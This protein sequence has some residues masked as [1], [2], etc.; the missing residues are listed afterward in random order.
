MFPQFFGG[1]SPFGFPK[2]QPQQKVAS[3][4]IRTPGCSHSSRAKRT[5]SAAEAASSLLRIGPG[6]DLTGRRTLNFPRLVGWFELAGRSICLNSAVLRT[7]N[8]SH[9]SVQ[10]LLPELCHSFTQLALDMLAVGTLVTSERAIRVVLWVY[11]LVCI[12]LSFFVFSIAR[13]VLELCLAH[14]VLTL[15]GFCWAPKA[16]KPT[17]PEPWRFAYPALR[18]NSVRKSS[19]TDFWSVQFAVFAWYKVRT[20]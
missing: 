16:L 20:R 17:F 14:R 8:P 13:A 19:Q 1:G 9:F 2:R 10:P 15:R 11:L 7:P 18:H 4:E 12:C 3:T 6:L 5:R